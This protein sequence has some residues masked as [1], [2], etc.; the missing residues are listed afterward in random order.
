MGNA[1][2]WLPLYWV[3]SQIPEEGSPYS[4]ESHL[5]YTIKLCS[6]IALISL[7]SCCLTSWCLSCLPPLG[8]RSARL[9]LLLCHP[10]LLLLIYIYFAMIEEYICHITL[11]RILSGWQK[12][13]VAS[14]QKSLQD[15]NKYTQH[16]L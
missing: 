8:M 15:S 2:Y 1:T 5:P 3:C 6:S 14:Y 4:F 13:E 7:P 12:R 16:L 11:L 9:S 10:V